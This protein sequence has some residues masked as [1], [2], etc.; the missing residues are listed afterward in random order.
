VDRDCAA[1]VKSLRKY[2]GWQ[3]RGWRFLSTTITSNIDRE[4]EM[5]LNPQLLKAVEYKVRAAGFWSFG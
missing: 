1:S 2:F 4:I 3:M 5:A